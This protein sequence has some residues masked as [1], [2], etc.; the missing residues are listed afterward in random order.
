[1]TQRKSERR[2]QGPILNSSCDTVKLYRWWQ[3]HTR[4]KYGNRSEC[5]SEREEAEEDERREGEA[6]WRSCG[7]VMSS[8]HQKLD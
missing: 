6:A 3:Q 5:R 2:E 7:V 1:M 8:F 4:A